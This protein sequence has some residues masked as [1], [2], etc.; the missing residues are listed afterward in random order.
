MEN[1]SKSGAVALIHGPTA[2]KKLTAEV[3]D[4]QFL[5]LQKKEYATDR[6]WGR[7]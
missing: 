6:S 1:L 3:E 5:H 7:H 4:H 2:C